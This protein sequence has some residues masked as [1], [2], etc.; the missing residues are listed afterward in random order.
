MSDP[1]VRLRHVALIV[2]SL[3]T[4]ERV[5]RNTLGLAPSGRAAI[6]REGI[7]VSFVPVG[8]SQI[9]LMEPAEPHNALGRFLATRGEGIHHIALEVA[10]LRAAMDRARKAGL[11]LI[12]ASP[13][14]GAHRT[15]VVFIHPASTHGALIELVEPAAAPDVPFSRLDPP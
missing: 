6:D 1:G 10:D 8:A 4:A 7:R 3:D 14:L 12:D 15:Q 11:R 13:R 2:R 9:E 5:C